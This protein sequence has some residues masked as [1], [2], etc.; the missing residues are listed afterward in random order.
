MIL[1]R[2]LHFSWE[3]P[4]PAVNR[5]IS[6]F[7]HLLTLTDNGSSDCGSCFHL[8]TRSFS[9]NTTSPILTTL[10]PDDVVSDVMY[11]LAMLFWLCWE[12]FGL[13]S[14]Y[15]ELHFVLAQKE[16]Q[17]K[18]GCYPIFGLMWLSRSNQWK[19]LYIDILRCLAC[20][21]PCFYSSRYQGLCSRCLADH[22]HY[23]SRK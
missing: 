3:A 17:T 19:Y 6:S 20:F 22:L 8:M 12:C 15:W 18:K 13:G 21:M 2:L 11:K 5:Q 16:D 4:K 14:Y 1:L 23:A 10:N 9:F 7:L